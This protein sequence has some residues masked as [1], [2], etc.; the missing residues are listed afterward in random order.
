[1]QKRFSDFKKLYSQLISIYLEN[2]VPPLPDKSLKN[3]IS[4]DDS[5]FVKTRVKDLEYFL[6]RINSHPKLKETDEFKS[7]LCKI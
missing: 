5:I 2:L 1:M 3:F 7:F 4:N 6:V